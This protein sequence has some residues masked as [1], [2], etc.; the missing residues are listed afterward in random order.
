MKE[1]RRI[2]TKII[3]IKLILSSILILTFTF[4]CDITLVTPW[5][6]VDTKEVDKLLAS[7]DEIDVDAR[8]V[9]IRF[10]FNP[11]YSHTRCRPIFCSSTPTSFSPA[12]VNFFFENVKEFGYLENDF[13]PILTLK[14]VW[15]INKDRKFYMEVNSSKI[16][17]NDTSGGNFFYFKNFKIIVPEL[18]K[19]DDKETIVIEFIYKNKTYLIKS[20]IDH[21]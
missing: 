12:Q 7:Q 17:V 20:F 9:R 3:K 21:Y 5:Q 13:D 11:Q 8:K 2:K 6:F 16:I 1:I 18:Y 4:S 10:T 15:I 19:P 14:K